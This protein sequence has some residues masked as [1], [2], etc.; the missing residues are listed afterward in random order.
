MLMHHADA[1]GGSG[2]GRGDCH[3]VSVEHNR[4]AIRSVQTRQNI[5][6]R[7]FSRAVFTQY[8]MDAASLHV[9]RYA[10]EGREATKTFSDFV[11][12]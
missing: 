7:R 10:I 8:G 2:G 1:A 6:Q 4:A 5:H 12:D 9:H 3:R 11:E